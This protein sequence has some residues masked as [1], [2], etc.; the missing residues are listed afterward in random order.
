MIV[1]LPQALSKRMPQS[2]PLR[3]ILSMQ[4]P[5]NALLPTA[6]VLTVEK[7]MINQLYWVRLVPLVSIRVTIGHPLLPRQEALDPMMGDGVP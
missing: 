3:L 6:Q 2:Q 4:I 1:A 7:R 5:T